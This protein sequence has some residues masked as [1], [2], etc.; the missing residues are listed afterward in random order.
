MIGKFIVLEGI[1]GCGKTTQCKLLK[2]YLI[3]KGYELI[4]TREPGG[5]L[6]GEQ[7][8]DILLD[9]KNSNMYP[10]SEAFLYAAA[11]AQ[12]VDEKIKPAINGGMLVICD[13]FVDSTLA[14]QGYG[15]GISIGLLEQ[16][17]DIA[18]GS[19]KPDLV[20]ILDLDVETSNLRLRKKTADDRLEME[21]KAF[22]ENV[23]RGY[24]EIAR[25]KGNYV[26]LDA[27]LSIDELHKRIL[28]V[29]EERLFE[30]SNRA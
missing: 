6:V 11:R 24:L 9:K 21:N 5:T 15:R 22:Y 16:I 12:L 30:S 17:N 27:S 26:V 23:R 18:T 13:R 4:Y 8:R 10:V 7:I 20:I 29:L 19:L 1:D 25:D 3:N 14:Y 28:S 2:E